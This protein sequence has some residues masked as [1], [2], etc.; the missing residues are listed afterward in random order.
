[1][2]C[3]SPSSACSVVVTY[4][5]GR[6]A[7]EF[8]VRLALGAS[9]GMILRVVLRQGLL[10]ALSG[11]IVGVA[12]ALAAERAIAGLFYEVSPADPLT[13]LASVLL[14]ALVA[15]AASHVPARR[16][17]RRIGSPR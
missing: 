10:M 13:L 12:G 4:L 17:S 6:R 2:A 7:Q 16:A 14:L 11:A 9:P 1:L 8:C 3:C 15:L 5:V